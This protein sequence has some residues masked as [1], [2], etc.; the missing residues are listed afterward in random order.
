MRSIPIYLYSYL[1]KMANKGSFHFISSLDGKP[2]SFQ[3]W[4]VKQC[5][6]TSVGSCRNQTHQRGRLGGCSHSFW[7]SQ[8]RVTFKDEGQRGRGR[9]HHRLNIRWPKRLW[10]MIYLEILQQNIRNKVA[11]RNQIPW[12]RLVTARGRFIILNEKYCKKTYS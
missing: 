4:T 10:D 6:L 5:T 7:D 2:S 11:H 8:G 9:A 1:C 12:D 3:L